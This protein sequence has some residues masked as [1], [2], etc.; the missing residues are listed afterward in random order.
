MNRSLKTARKWGV[1][2]I[3]V[4]LSL[5][6]I[7]ATLLLFPG[8]F[9]PHRQQ[10]GALTIRSDRP[11]RHDI[12]RVVEEVRTRVA[13]M[14]YPLTDLPYRVFV[15][16]DER[17]Y[18]LL[19]LV[20]RRPSRT[21]GFVLSIPG[22]IY[23]NATHIRRV[24]R[25]QAGGVRHWRFQGSLADAIAHELAH[26][27]SRKALGAAATGRLPAWKAEGYADYQVHRAPILADSAYSLTDRIDLLLDDA[28]W[29][30]AAN[31]RRL[32]RWQL[33]AEYLAG[34]KKLGLRGIADEAITESAVY[35]EMIEWHRLTRGSPVGGRSAMPPRP[36]VWH[37]RRRQVAHGDVGLPV[38]RRLG[39]GSE[40]TPV[41]SCPFLTT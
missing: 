10:F 31:E 2:G 19:S 21:Q 30:G 13:A 28:L 7:A 34:V 25:P 15:C 18:G 3:L 8:P 40:S 12:A 5:G 4:F 24:G 33:M 16:E 39:A 11:L 17:L 26:L 23:L 6:V 41:P 14:E 38:G 9:L 1:A 35:S 36:S 32:F 20:L 37:S 27:S 29:S 22:N